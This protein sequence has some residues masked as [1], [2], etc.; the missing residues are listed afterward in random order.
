MQRDLK[1]S[2]KSVVAKNANDGKYA[3]DAEI[4]KN[5]K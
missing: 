4:P 2:G 5:S 3:K 1:N